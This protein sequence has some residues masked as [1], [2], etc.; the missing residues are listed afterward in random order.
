ML[1]ANFKETGMAVLINEQ[2]WHFRP[3]IKQNCRNWICQ[4]GFKNVLL[5]SLDSLLG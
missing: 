2:I 5:N 4:F 1:D 3:K